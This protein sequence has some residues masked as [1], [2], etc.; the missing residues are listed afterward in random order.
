MEEY[1]FTCGKKKMI[2]TKITGLLFIGA[3]L[4]ILASCATTKAVENADV[5]T[6]AIIEEEIPAAEKIKKEPKQISVQN[7]S[8]QKEIAFKELVDSLELKVVSSPKTVYSNK[9]FDSPYVVSVTGKDGPEKNLDITVSYPS[10]RTNDSITYNNIQLKTDSDGKITFKPEK[11]GF[12][13]KGEVTFYPTPISS[14]SNIV[15]ASFNAA[16]KAPFV[17]KSSY[18]TYPYGIL[19]VYDFNE[20]GRPTTNNFTLL[21]TLRNA[22]VSVGNSPISDTSYFNKSVSELYTANHNIVGNMYNFLVIGSFKYAEPAVE[23]AEK[24][25]ATVKL[26]ADITCVDMKNGNIIYKTAIE[27]SATDKT[28]WNAEQKC[29]KLL[30]EKT[31]DAIIYGM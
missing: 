4:S 14:N 19:Y 22:G 10:A 31:A 3:T 28:K 12:A 7:T 30:A 25:T 29:R 13:V 17:V 6:E 16:V 18:V 23:D 26:V 15:Q 27:E 2:K 20:K 5:D 1:H 8:N 21:Q 24:S 11:T 9:N